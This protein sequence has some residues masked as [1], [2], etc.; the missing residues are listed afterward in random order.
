MEGRLCARFLK[1]VLQGRIEAPSPRISKQAVAGFREKSVPIRRRHDGRG[2]VEQVLEGLLQAPLVPGFEE[3]LRNL[4]SAPKSGVA[5][6][7]ETSGRGSSGLAAQVSG[8][9]AVIDLIDPDGALRKWDGDCINSALE[10]D[11]TGQVVADSIGTRQYSGVGGQMDFIRGA[12][13]SQ[14]GKP[15]LALRSTASGGKIS[16]IVPEP[17]LLARMVLMMGAMTAYEALFTIHL[18]ATPGKLATGLRV[19]GRRAQLRLLAARVR[20]RDP[21]DG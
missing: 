12:A 2:A 20:R 11:L 18:R 17:R 3:R 16:R 7:S 1:A 10:I 14:G 19:A 9:Q 5:L 4:G 6:L 21:R 13:L 15:I 8:P